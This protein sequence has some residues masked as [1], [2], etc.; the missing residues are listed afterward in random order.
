MQIEYFGIVSHRHNFIGP[1]AGYTQLSQKIP[2][3]IIP[4]RV[5]PPAAPITINTSLQF[6]HTAHN[7]VART[8]GKVHV[9]LPCQNVLFCVISNS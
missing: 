3:R 2:Y 7:T 8:R 5:P 1:G 9:L 4:K 6:P